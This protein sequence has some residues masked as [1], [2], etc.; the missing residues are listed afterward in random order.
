[1]ALSNLYLVY[2]IRSFTHVMADLPASNLVNA[3][4]LFFL[5]SCYFSWHSFTPIMEF[6]DLME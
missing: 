5:Q 4:V 2:M 3:Q 6:N 1:M